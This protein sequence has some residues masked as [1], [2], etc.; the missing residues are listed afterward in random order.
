[1]NIWINKI[2]GDLN[3]INGLNHYIGMKT[4][5]PDSIKELTLMPYILGALIFLGISV[6]I[7]GKETTY[8]MGS[9]FYDV[10]NS[11]RN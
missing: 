4:I 2:T 1:M 11:G 8:G 7:A 3:T 9:L 5:Q 6:T 10:R